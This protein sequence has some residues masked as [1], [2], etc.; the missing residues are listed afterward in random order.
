MLLSVEKGRA[1]GQLGL[2]EKPLFQGRGTPGGVDFGAPFLHKP[3]KVT[4]LSSGAA[5]FLRQF[6]GKP[7]PFR[8]ARAMGT[9]ALFDRR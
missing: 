5:R 8:R 9:A 2:E 4:A 3:R 1:K 6:R 7:Q